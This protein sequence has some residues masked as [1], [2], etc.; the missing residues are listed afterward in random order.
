MESQHMHA[1]VS[2]WDVTVGNLIFL[3]FSMHLSLTIFKCGFQIMFISR[4]IST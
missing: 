4:T 2:M 3:V 1:Y